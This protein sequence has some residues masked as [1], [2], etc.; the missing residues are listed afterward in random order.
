LSTYLVFSQRAEARLDEP[1][2][3]GHAARFFATR[4][5]VSAAGVVVGA[6][7]G[8][9]ERAVSGRARTDEDLARADA[10]EA[11]TKTAG[12]A[13]L[14]RR[15][16]TVWLV[17]TDGDDDRVALRVAA[18]LAGVFLGPIV[19]PDGGAIFGP[20]TAREKLESRSR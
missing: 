15:C 17:A 8:S 4:L 9:G 5:G 20:K 16:P 11:Q 18:I 6:D 13:Q 3:R 7:D 14:A 12:L 2:L 19:A 10:A 1:E